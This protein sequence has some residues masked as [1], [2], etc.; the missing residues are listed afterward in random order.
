MNHRIEIQKTGNIKFP[1]GIERR[2][3]DSTGE[4]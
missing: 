3:K 4:Q 2:I 1:N